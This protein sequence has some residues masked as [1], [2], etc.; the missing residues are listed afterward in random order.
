MCNMID[1]CIMWYIVLYNE[2]FNT[3]K[4]TDYYIVLDIVL[5]S[6]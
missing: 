2:V 1:Y 6:N 5:G 3:F 4:L